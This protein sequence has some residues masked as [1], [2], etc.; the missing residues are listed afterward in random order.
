[1]ILKRNRQLVYLAWYKFFMKKWNIATVMFLLSLVLTS[2][3]KSVLDGDGTYGFARNLNVSG[4]WFQPITVTIEVFDYSVVPSRWVSLGSVSSPETS[5]GLMGSTPVFYWNTLIDI[6]QRFYRERRYAKLRFRQSVTGS[7][8][9]ANVYSR[10]GGFCAYEQLDVNR[11]ISCNEDFSNLDDN[12][13][14][15]ENQMNTILYHNR[16]VYFPD[17]MEVSSY[18]GSGV[19]SLTYTQGYGSRMLITSIGCQSPSTGPMN[20]LETGGIT[21]TTLIEHYDSSQG[22]GGTAS[23]VLLEPGDTARTGYSLQGF[24]GRGMDCIISSSPLAKGSTPIRETYRCPD[25]IDATVRCD[26]IRREP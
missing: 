13:P 11:L 12:D 5:N 22:R 4:V 17:K 7:Y 8:E 19:V 24:T 16:N 2:C 6:P 14:L 26:R 18:D 1:M 3:V 9:F 25:F 15:A 10:N 20:Q 21:S 23:R